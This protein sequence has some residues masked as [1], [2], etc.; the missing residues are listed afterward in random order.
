MFFCPRCGSVMISKGGTLVCPKCGTISKADP[1]TLQY[2]KKTSRFTK[3]HEKKVD[4]IGIDVPVSAIV[5]TNIV[6]PKCGHK[7]AYY[8]RRHR[9]SAESSDVIEK[10]Y[11]CTSCGYNWSETA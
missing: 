10:V 3:I 6:C 1:S 11:R 9:S 7:G 4:V 8:W 2:L 5:D